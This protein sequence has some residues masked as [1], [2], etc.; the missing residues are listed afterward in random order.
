MNC[1]IKAKPTSQI[2]DEYYIRLIN[3]QKGLL[4]SLW[5]DTVPQP[6]SIIIQ[7]TDNVE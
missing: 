4:I 5:T 2:P 1:V 7:I 6:K 3:N